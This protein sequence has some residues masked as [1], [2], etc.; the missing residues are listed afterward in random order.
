MSQKPQNENENELWDLI[1]DNAEEE[2]KAESKAAS[3]PAPEQKKSPWMFV[4]CGLGIALIVTLIMLFTGGQGG[5]SAANPSTPGN[6]GSAGN[7]AQ[8]QELQ[9]QVDNLTIEREELLAQIETMNTDAAAQDM[10]I[11]ELLKLY[12]E[13]SETLE[14]VESN[15]MYNNAENAEKLQQT[16]EAYTLLIKAQNAFLCYDEETLNACIE[17]LMDDLELFD[18]E[19]LTAFYNVMEYMEQPYWKNRD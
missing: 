15:A 18:Q 7:A 19:A 10:K 2:P 3:Q 9:A 4:S 6:P 12:N 8:V 14:Y 16:M 13:M 1:Q 11:E 17:E 5:T